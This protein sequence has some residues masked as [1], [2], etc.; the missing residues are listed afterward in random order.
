MS[1]RSA[2][3]AG[4]RGRAVDALFAASATQLPSTPWSSAHKSRNLNV[5]DSRKHGGCSSRDGL[6]SRH[7]CHR[8]HHHQSNEAAADKAKSEGGTT[9]FDGDDDLVGAVDHLLN[10]DSGRGQ[11]PKDGLDLCSS[12]WKSVES[13]TRA[14]AAGQ[15]IMSTISRCYSLPGLAQDSSPPAVAVDLHRSARETGTEMMHSSLASGRF[16]ARALAI[17]RRLGQ[18]PPTQPDCL[19]I[20]SS[21]LAE[22]AKALDPG[23]DEATIRAWMKANGFKHQQSKESLEALSWTE[24]RQALSELSPAF[25]RHGI[26]FKSSGEPAIAT[27]T[28]VEASRLRVGSGRHADPPSSRNNTNLANQPC[29]DRWED[30]VDRKA[31]CASFP[32]QRYSVVQSEGD[33]HRQ[34]DGFRD[35]PPRSPGADSYGVLRRKRHAA[36]SLDYEAIT[37]HLPQVIQPLDPSILVDHIKAHG[38]RERKNPGSD[39]AGLSLWSLDPHDRLTKMPLQKDQV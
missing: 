24:Y 31:S 8:S 23:V 4:E 3:T 9:T 25:R 12:T 38:R 34:G 30:V 27:M 28:P 18:A 36:V 5:T 19:Y 21:K 15:S 7:D 26:T 17:F 32:P 13:M 29:R 39:V 22:A 1:A 35:C 2:D 6:L 33:N 11:E 37:K 10:S 20:N 16:A 14:L